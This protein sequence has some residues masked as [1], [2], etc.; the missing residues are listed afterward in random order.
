MQNNDELIEKAGKYFLA[1]NDYLKSID[2]KM[3]ISVFGRLGLDLA[4]IA[5]NTTIDLD[6]VID[7][8]D[9]SVREE[10]YK[11]AKKCDIKVDIVPDSFSNENDGE[12]K[13]IKFPKD[14]FE[15]GMETEIIKR[16][17]RSL[18]HLTVDILN[19]CDMII[20]KLS[21]LKTRDREDIYAIVEKLHITASE[22]DERYGKFEFDPSTKAAIDFRYNKLIDKLKKQEKK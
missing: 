22:L 21:R 19:P 12:Y 11:I 9:L 15:K 20:T 17:N 7:H 6:I 1:C 18:S 3:Q 8:C 10:L 13:K 5:R 4:D 16:W 2:R 14:Y